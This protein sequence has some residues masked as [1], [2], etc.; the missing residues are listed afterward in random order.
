MF[1]WMEKHVQST[2]RRGLER[3]GPFTLVSM[4]KTHRQ[5]QSIA[6]ALTPWISSSRCS[7]WSSRTHQGTPTS[8]DKKT[9][10][11]NSTEPYRQLHQSNIIPRKYFYMV[12]CW[13]IGLSRSRALHDQRQCQTHKNRRWVFTGHGKIYLAPTYLL[14]QTKVRHD[15]HSQL[16]TVWCP[17][18]STNWKENWEATHT[19]IYTQDRSVYMFF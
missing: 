14:S 9:N 6:K 11:I 8:R 17:F 5:G 13:V 2:L 12:H 4:V 1:W 15:F 7:A 18:F 10:P 16:Q 3:T 19:H